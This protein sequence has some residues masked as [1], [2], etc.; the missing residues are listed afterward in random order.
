M[1]YIIRIPGLLEQD[2]Q[3][4]VLF[5]HWSFVGYHSWRNYL[6]GRMETFNCRTTDVGSYSREDS[7][8]QDATRSTDIAIFTHVSRRITCPCRI[9]F[10]CSTREIDCAN[11]CSYN[12]SHR[13]PDVSKIFFDGSTAVSSNIM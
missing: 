8:P 12:F 9:F 3:S 6:F 2:R 5:R 11:A 7:Y 4:F 13:S 1:N 10:F